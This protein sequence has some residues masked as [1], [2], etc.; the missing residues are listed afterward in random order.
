MLADELDYVVGVDTHWTSTSLPSLLRHRARL[1]Q[2]GRHVRARAATPLR[3]SLR[4][5]SEEIAFA[6]GRLRAP[7]A[8]ANAR[9]GA[10]MS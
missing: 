4:S 5:R 10:T 6:C 8:V 1:S 9:L 7:A 3:F 2:S